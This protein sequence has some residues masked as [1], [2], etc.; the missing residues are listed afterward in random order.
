VFL[1]WAFF[2]GLGLQAGSSGYITAFSVNSYSTAVLTIESSA[3]DL[4]SLRLDIAI[5]SGH[6]DVKGPFTHYMILAKEP[7]DVNAR[8]TED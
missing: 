1:R 8:Y 3:P 7:C 6:E 5:A 2:G 4:E